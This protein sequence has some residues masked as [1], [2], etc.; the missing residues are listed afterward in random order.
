MD[1]EETDLAH[2]VGPDRASRDADGAREIAY[3]RGEIAEAAEREREL[4]LS[5]ARRT[6]ELEAARSA[7]LDVQGSLSWKALLRFRALRDRL[8]PSG[9]LARRGY[10]LLIRGARS[11][12]RILSRRKS[13]GDFPT[14]PAQQD[15]VAEA[16]RALAEFEQ[17]RAVRD[18]PVVVTI[19][20][21]TMLL[22]GEG[23]RPTQLALE[24]SRRG[25]PVVFL[26]WRWTND[27]WAAQDRLAQNVFQLP[28][29][30]VTRAPGVLFDAFTNQE[31]IVLFEFPHPSFFAALAAADSAGWT[32]VYDVLDDWEEFH[33][34]GQAV[35][36][37]ADFE[38]HLASSVDAVFA[39]NGF[40]AGQVRELAGREPEVNGNGLRP[41]IA[42]VDVPR[43]LER[44][45]I[46]VGYFGYLAGAWFDWGLIAAAAAERPGWRF[47]LIGYGGSPEGVRLPGNVQLLGKKPY[48]EL[49]SYAA[50]W[51]VATVPFLPDRLAAGA[52]PIKIYEYLALG[53]P[54]VVTGVHA[55]PGAEALVTR[56]EGVA[57]FLHR[58]EHAAATRGSSSEERR[59]YAVANTW[60]SRVDAML[61][62]VREGRQGVALKRRIFGEPA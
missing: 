45:T 58:V 26:Y 33:R 4:K 5:L 20:S 61:T 18:A 29:D 59:A 28:L 41:E 16:L 39:V 1:R 44:G 52:D 12:I 62:S 49:A 37:D 47:H 6:D 13:A 27:V 56:A 38:R 7:L 30:V 60:A 19:F 21:A 9:S 55:P 10:D 48:H 23:Q 15:R 22:E 17:R 42:R 3:L 46:T 36:W 2:D 34:V 24:L 43:A 31:R 8:A 25:V 32:T 40:L 11:S 54:V 51:D 50:N 57:D 53:L 35:W 14:G